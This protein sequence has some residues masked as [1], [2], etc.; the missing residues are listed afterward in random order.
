MTTLNYKKTY[1]NKLLSSFNSLETPQPI[2]R[3][4]LLPSTSTNTYD[5]T[6]ILNN[7]N[8]NKSKHVVTIPY[9]QYEIKTL[10][11]E[12]QNLKQAQQKDSAILQHLLSKLENQSDSKL[13]TENQS[14]ENHALSNI[15]HVSQDFLHVL[16]QITSKKHIIKI[17]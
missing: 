9:L 7:N 1:L 10:K 3:P 15:K 16:T 13:E 6:K 5:L 17:H 8:K 11:I 12:L 2:Q 4:V 14:L